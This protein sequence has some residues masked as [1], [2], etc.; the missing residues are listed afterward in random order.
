[1]QN[2]DY[3]PILKNLD[4][5]GDIRLS[6]G[7]VIDNKKRTKREDPR[8]GISS[9]HFGNYW[10][11]LGEDKVIFKSFECMGKTK[12]NRIVNE[13]LFYEISKQ[14]GIDCAKCKLASIDGIRGIASYNVLNK[15][16][17][18]ITGSML[19]YKAGDYEY[20]NTLKSYYNALKILK[21]K[22]YK[23]NIRKETL[24]LYQIC[25]IDE[26]LLHTDRHSENIQ[27]IEN[28]KTNEIRLSPIF[29]NEFAFC[30]FNLDNTV[31]DYR[32]IN[33][34]IAKSLFSTSGN[35]LLVDN[36]D[37]G[38]SKYDKTK[39]DL[40]IFASK[41][42]DAK[43][44]LIDTLDKIDIKSAIANVEN[45]GIVI[46]EDY[47]DLITMITCESVNEFEHTINMLQHILNNKEKYGIQKL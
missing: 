25:L 21:S 31:Q 27:F 35:L 28:T 34:D 12:P 46:S 4:K 20:N 14:V 3:K 43:K 39:N 13:L 5:Y 17:K 16:E 41:N 37:S 11:Y 7:I 10:Y 22:G 30:S 9:R 26:L 40:V 8:T 32:T 47:K 38:K 44:I 18:L 36:V 6:P 29:D 42:K 19:K 23:I 45:M 24:K 1:M 33:F 15:D 2:I